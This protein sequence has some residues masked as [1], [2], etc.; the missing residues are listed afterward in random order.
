MSSTRTRD[1][2]TTG[3]VAKIC[4]VAPRTVS[5]WFDNGSLKGYRIP[6]S[7]DRRI[8][9]TQLVRFMKQHEIPLDGLQ[10][11]STRVLFID[12]ASETLDVLAKVLT[13]QAHYAVEITHGGFSAG[14]TA[15]KFRPHVILVDMHLDSIKGEDVVK[16]VRNSNELQMSKVVAISGKLTDGQGQHLLQ[17]GFD[18]YLRKP[19]H[20]KSVIDAIEQATNVFG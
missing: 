8:P 4:N 6:G 17:Q 11:G 12:A 7:K 18:G 9:M 5:K 20:A 16:M 15:E 1:I 10:S 13:E 2:L 19:F 3:E 14:V